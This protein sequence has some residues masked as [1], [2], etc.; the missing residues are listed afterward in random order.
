MPTEQEPS[1]LEEVIE[2]INSIT[3]SEDKIKFGQILEQVGRRSFG[4]LLL[5]A[6]L[7]TL[8]PFIGDIPGLPTIT[9]LFVLL[10]SGQLLF[11]GRQIWLPQWMLN[12]SLTQS[13]VN[14]ALER[15]RRPSRFVDRVLRQRFKLLVH[16][17]GIHVIAAVCI[18]IAVLM[19]V[20]EVVPFSANLA[21]A[22]LTAFGLSLISNDGLLALVAYSITALIFIVIL[23]IIL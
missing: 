21:G 12:R 18:V 23:S 10:I 3:G 5:V 8:A 15:L 20:M 16:G 13:K 7:L 14:K 19:P 9:A 4:I 6:G 11:Y 2:R 22:A 17:S 1:S